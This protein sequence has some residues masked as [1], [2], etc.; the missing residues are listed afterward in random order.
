[1]DP[2]EF[3]DNYEDLSTDKGFQFKFICERCG[4]GYLSTY[5]IS[6]LGLAGGLLG[7]VSSLFG[8]LLGQAADSAYEVQRAVGGKA[9]DDA[10][11]EAV[12]EIRPKFVQ[13]R[14]CGQWVCRDVCLHS[15]ANMCK[16]CAPIAEETETSAR[17]QHVHEQVANDLALEEEQRV[18]AKAQQVKIKC[19]KCGQATGGA[20]FCPHCGNRTGDVP[21]FCPGCGA[22]GAPGAKFCGECGEA[23]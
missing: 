18:Q 10:L 1:M 21:Q 11:R 6:K 19:R 14:H 2:I 13:C 15:T 17:A 16:D 7:A 5:K 12:Q 3:T 23:L 4:N 20:K 9:H 22:K 8:G